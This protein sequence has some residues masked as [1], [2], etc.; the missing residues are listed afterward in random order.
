MADLTMR[1]DDTRDAEAPLVKLERALM[2]LEATQA[3][4]WG[5]RAEGNS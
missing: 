2:L 3:R 5:Q 1:V 4:P